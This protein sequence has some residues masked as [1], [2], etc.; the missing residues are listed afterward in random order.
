MAR[1]GYRASVINMSKNVANAS[2]KELIKLKDQT[3]S[4][5]IDSLMEGNGDT[6]ML[7]EVEKWLVLDIH[8]ENSENKDYQVLQIVDTDGTTYKSGSASLI[9]AL[10]DIWDELFDGE[11][12]EPTAIR[13]I[14]KPSKKFQGKSFYT[15][16]L[17]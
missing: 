7:I 14:S 1:E 2:K 12:E 9:N 17:A 16:V 5:S 13:V 8:N 3:D 10:V 15:C 4:L 11:E 6:G